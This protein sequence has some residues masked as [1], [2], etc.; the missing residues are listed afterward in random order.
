MAWFLGKF[1]GAKA[2]VP[3]SR[4]S[5]DGADA[6]KAGHGIKLDYLFALQGV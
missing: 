1:D 5:T 2:I 4:K 3:V 6:C